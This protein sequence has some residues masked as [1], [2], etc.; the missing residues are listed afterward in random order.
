MRSSK[1]L[2]GDNPK[3]PPKFSKWGHVSGQGQ[4][5]VK[6]GAFRLRAVETSKLS[7]LGQ[8]LLRVLLNY[9]ERHWLSKCLILS[10]VQGQDQVTKGHHTKNTN[11]RG[12]AHVLS[13][14]LHVEYNG[15]VLL[16][17]RVH[18]G[19]PSY[20]VRSRSCQKFQ[21]LKCLILK[22]E[23]LFLMQNDPR[24]ALVPFIFCTLSRTPKITFDCMT[25]PLA[26]ML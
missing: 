3:A 16:A 9:R 22:T 15:D 7:V 12:V 8:N 10:S 21:I 6:I 17:I 24:I 23:D 5:K 13:A 1:A 20:K 19:E 25:S 2:N 4:V 18:L 14:I 11:I 26:V